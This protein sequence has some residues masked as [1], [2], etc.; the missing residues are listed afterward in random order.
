MAFWRTYYHLIWAT[1]ER[2]PF[3]TSEKE[4]LLYKYIVDKSDSLNCIIHAI[5]VALKTTFI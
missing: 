3:I 4:T 2:H 1:K 5:L